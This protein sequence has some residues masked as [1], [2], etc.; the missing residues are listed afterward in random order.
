MSTGPS[1]DRGADGLPSAADRRERAAS[2]ARSVL[3]PHGPAVSGRPWLAC[4]GAVLAA[5]AVALSAWAAHGVADAQVAARLQMAALFGF[6]HGLALAALAPWVRRR[7]G[8]AALCLLLAGTLL[9]SGSLAGQALAGWPTR[10]A[11]AG[12]LALIA[13]W[14][15]WALD[16]LRR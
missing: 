2:A 4:A 8:L 5:A 12:G 13:G 6:G 3:A 14:L 9:F 1:S 10:L 11:P 15:L 16:A 7:L